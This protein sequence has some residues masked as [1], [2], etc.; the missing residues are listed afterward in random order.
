[1]ERLRQLVL[2]ARFF[3]ALVVLTLFWGIAAIS[4]AFVRPRGQGF[5][6]CGRH[7][8]RGLLRA[9][10][11]EVRVD[12]LDRL[13]PGR[14]YVFMS[15]HQSHFDVLALLHALPFDLRAVAKR[16]LARVPLFGWALASAGFIFID[17]SDRERAIAS[18][19]RAQD[20]LRQ[21][22]SIL[23]FAEGT[24]SPD[25]RLLPF[26]KGGFMMALQTG[27]PVVPVAVSG[28]RE[29]LPKH[30]FRVRP[31]VIRV[32]VQPP[33]ET[34]GRGPQARDDLMAEVRSAI[35]RGLG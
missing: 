24:R 7:W 1:M 26:K 27:A 35:E 25:S 8:A 2:Q 4:C 11:V 32:R 15:N 14:S 18:L 12:G 22:R 20:I 9:A 6:R 30:S 3:A 28:S 13:A 5:I 33:I 23:V 31:G 34:A 10:G 16:E 19:G 29:V 21:G 17:R